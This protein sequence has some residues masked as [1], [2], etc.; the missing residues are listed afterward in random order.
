M[1]LLSTLS[2]AAEVWSTVEERRA[3]RDPSSQEDASVVEPFL[4]GA[5]RELQ[6]MTMRL[7][8]SLVYALSHE[9]EPE[10]RMAAVRRFNDLMTLQRVGRV[11][12]MVHQRLLSLYPAVTERLVEEA[13]VLERRCEALLEVDQPD[14]EDEAGVITVELPDLRDELAA[15]V[16]T[17]LLFTA[18][19][20][21][22]LTG[23]WG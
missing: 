19:L 11:L 15:F 17:V 16:E 21:S 1:L 8:A 14:L 18:H 20:Q 5:S 3:G 22:E 12:H 23:R 9:E 2:A 10:A 7:R 13:R 4:R 6:E